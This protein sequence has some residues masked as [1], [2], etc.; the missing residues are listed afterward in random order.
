MS[1]VNNLRR[2]T[3]KTPFSL[4]FRMEVAIP[5]EIGL[6]SISFTS[7]S[8]R[9][10]NVVMT[11]QLDLLEENREIVSIKLADYQKR[12][13]Q[14]YNQNMQPREFVARDLVLRKAV[15]SMKESSLRKL[16]PNWEGS[17]RVIAIAGVG[18]YYV[19]D[20]E[21]RPVPRPGN[22]SNLRKYFH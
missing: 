5:V 21:E 18:A 16:A 6:S 22:V 7:F 13:A 2:F 11:Q 14:G 17:Y 10:S 8:P 20:M 3:N 9:I 12:L 15:G 1:L 4:T 19:E